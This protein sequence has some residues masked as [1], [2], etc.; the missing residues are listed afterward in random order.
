MQALGKSKFFK[1]EANKAFSGKPMG[2][3]TATVGSL[4][5]YK[6]ETSDLSSLIFGVITWPGDITEV[7]PIDVLDGENKYERLQNAGRMSV[8]NS[9]QSWVVELKVMKH[10]P[11]KG[12][13][14][15]A[16]APYEDICAF[17]GPKEDLR[18]QLSRFGTLE[19]AS[20]EKLHGETNKNKTRLALKC[21]AGN[22][23]LLAAVWVITRV[24][25]VLEDY[26]M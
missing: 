22:M 3:D 6:V 1:L 2:A 21:D 17:L 18:A 11:S 16:T 20:R 19:I 12:Y 5:T 7:V 23:D 15:L 9:G 24:L 8:I 10:N 13:A 4:T 14:T 26:G 25:A